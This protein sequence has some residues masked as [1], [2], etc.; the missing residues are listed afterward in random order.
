[1][2]LF[3]CFKK[4]PKKRILYDFY[5]D[6]YVSVLWEWEVERG[7]KPN[8][9][10]GMVVMT[11]EK[12]NELESLLNK[13]KEFDQKLSLACELNNKGRELEKRGEFIDAIAIYEQNIL[14]D[15]H[16]TMHPY[17]RL[18][19]LY[20]KNKDYE[21][22]KRVCTLAIEEFPQEKKYKERLIKING[23]IEK[24]NTNLKK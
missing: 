10:Y 6:K 18:L 1:M 11:E 4:K 19:V 13:R 5:Y 21:N 20:R 14:P 12:F 3:D 22:E 24:Q 7:N 15:V 23:Y 17:D 2:G 8:I 16:V 9:E